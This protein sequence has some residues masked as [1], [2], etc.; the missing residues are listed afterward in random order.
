MPQTGNG[1]E[2]LS[3][4]TPYLK[5]QNKTT[6]NRRKE[7]GHTTDGG[8]IYWGGEGEMGETSDSGDRHGEERKEREEAGGAC[9]LWGGDKSTCAQRPS[10]QDPEQTICTA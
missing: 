4:F 7:S 8:F 3:S 9:L 6:K 5:K 2:S 10:C 1:Q